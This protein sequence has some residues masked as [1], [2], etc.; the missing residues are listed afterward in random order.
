M[1]HVNFVEN[2]SC[3]NAICPFMYL[4]V[5]CMPLDSI[6]TRSG[7]IYMLSDFHMS[8]MIGQHS[9]MDSVVSYGSDLSIIMSSDI[10]PR[11]SGVYLVNDYLVRGP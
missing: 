8:M 5:L 4:L 3:N 1:S 6:D 2:V 7:S 11:I 9:H 10:P